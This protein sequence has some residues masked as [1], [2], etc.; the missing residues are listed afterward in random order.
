[1]SFSD[2]LFKTTTT[3]LGLS[4]IVIGFGVCTTIAGGIGSHI[5]K[6]F[7]NEKVFYFY[8][9]LFSLISQV[10]SKRQD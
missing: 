10:N 2:L 6:S 7:Q 1:M 5:T 8:Y 3:F 4:T 9:E